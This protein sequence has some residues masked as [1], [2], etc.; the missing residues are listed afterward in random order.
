MR[1]TCLLCVLKHLGDAITLWY[2]IIQGYEE[3]HIALYI[4]ALS[5]AEQESGSQ[6][7]EISETL[8][9]ERRLFLDSLLGYQDAGDLYEADLLPVIKLCLNEIRQAKPANEERVTAPR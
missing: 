1:P 5:Q 2:E 4:G 7:P 9:Q 8:A 6:C 3:E